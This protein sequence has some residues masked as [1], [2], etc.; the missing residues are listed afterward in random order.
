MGPIKVENSSIGL[1]FFEN[2]SIYVMNQRLIMGHL[3]IFSIL[4]IING[5]DL[6]S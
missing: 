2:I 6:H 4:K 3:A 1:D 5:S